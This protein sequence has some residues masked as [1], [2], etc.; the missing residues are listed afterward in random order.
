MEPEGV[1]FIVRHADYSCYAC[2]SVRSPS[3]LLTGLMQFT[4]QLYITEVTTRRKGYKQASE[5][6]CRIKKPRRIIPPG[7]C[8]HLCYEHRKG[9]HT[10]EVERQNAL[11]ASN[12][13]KR[14]SNRS[15]GC[16]T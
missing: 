2:S 11:N 5:R 1:D 12:R 15:R 4:K 3:I 14:S 10:L 7:L 13:V 6:I 9:A 8:S 16:A